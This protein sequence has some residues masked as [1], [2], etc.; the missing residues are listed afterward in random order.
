VLPKLKGSRAII[1][2][3]AKNRDETMR[4]LDKIDSY[5]GLDR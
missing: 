2:F 1:S 3:S 4:A 5:L